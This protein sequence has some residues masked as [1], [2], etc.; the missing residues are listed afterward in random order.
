MKPILKVKID[1]FFVVI[2]LNNY[3]KDK[4]INMYI[5]TSALI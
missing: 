5:I 1:T 4:F 2:L 3:F